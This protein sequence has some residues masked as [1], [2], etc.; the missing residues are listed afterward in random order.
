MPVGAVPELCDTYSAAKTDSCT[1][2]QTLENQ[3]KTQI[4]VANRTVAEAK[5]P[6]P[7]NV[8]RDRNLL[9]TKNYLHI[10]QVIVSKPKQNPQTN[11]HF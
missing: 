5:V 8:T 11:H 2:R 4:S 6:L 1:G 9:T 10:V 7:R 3:C